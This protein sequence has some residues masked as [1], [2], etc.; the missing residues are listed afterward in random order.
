MSE[1]P[2][3]TNNDS[4][5]PLTKIAVLDPSKLEPKS[6]THPAEPPAKK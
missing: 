2:K 3:S 6:P 5:A 1:R 4:R